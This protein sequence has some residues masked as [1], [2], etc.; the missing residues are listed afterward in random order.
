MK[1]D[2][3]DVQPYPLVVFTTT[4]KITPI[5]SHSKGTNKRDFSDAMDTEK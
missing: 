2:D 3:D 5:A 4:E 1:D